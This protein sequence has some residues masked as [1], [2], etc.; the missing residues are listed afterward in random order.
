[1][2]SSEHRLAQLGYRQ[3]LK[4]ALSHFGNFAISFSLQ[5]IL[6]G[7][8]SKYDNAFRTFPLAYAYCTT[9]VLIVRLD[10]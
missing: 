7:I 3:D 6:S 4:R 10:I 5:S 8:T 9:E 1:M 2:D